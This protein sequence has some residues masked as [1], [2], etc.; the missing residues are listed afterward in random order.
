[1]QNQHNRI[2]SMTIPTNLEKM[3]EQCNREMIGA[4]RQFSRY[5]NDSPLNPSNYP[6]YNIQKLNDDEYAITIAIAGFAKENVEITLEDNLLTIA[7]EQEC[8]DKLDESTYLYRGIAN[9]D[10]KVRFTLGEY[11]EVNGATFENGLLNLSLMRKVP[12][13]KKPKTIKIK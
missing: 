7:G 13:A 2:L 4:E 8:E 11:I 10:F 5:F 3:F 6:P 9:R 1:M 12:D